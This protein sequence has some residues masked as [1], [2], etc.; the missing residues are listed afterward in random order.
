MDGYWSSGVLSGEITR[1]ESEESYIKNANWHDEL[2]DTV[3]CTLF[4]IALNKL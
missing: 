2:I 1:I 3:Q 4:E